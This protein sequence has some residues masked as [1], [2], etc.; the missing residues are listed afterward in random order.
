MVLTPTEVFKVSKKYSVLILDNSRDQNKYLQGLREQEKGIMP[1]AKDVT[2]IE[3]LGIPYFFKWFRR[4]S[5]DVCNKEIGRLY[6]SGK[7]DFADN[8]SLLIL[9][10]DSSFI[11]RRKKLIPKLLGFIA[12]NVFEKDVMI[13]LVCAKLKGLGTALISYI[14]RYAKNYNKLIIKLDAAT[15][16]LACKFYPKFGFLLSEAD[17]EYEERCEGSEINKEGLDP[18]KIF[19]MEKILGKNVDK[20]VI[21]QQSVSMRTRGATKKRKQILDNIRY[22]TRGVTRRL[23]TPTKAQTL[24]LRIQE[25]SAS[26]KPRTK[27]GFRT[28]RK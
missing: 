27:K 21:R 18:N 13:D 11:T 2:K 9:V 3:N 5:F 7:F 6:A 28:T 12:C 23:Q 15:I 19:K 26:N 20:E 17:E 10:F 25:T 16:E 22:M 1:S 8:D 4:Q 14:I 24:K